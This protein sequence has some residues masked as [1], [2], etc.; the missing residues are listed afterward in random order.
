MTE[1]DKLR[2]ALDEALRRERIAV[3]ELQKMRQRAEIA[4]KTLELY[5]RATQDNHNYETVHNARTDRQAD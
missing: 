5:K 2:T 1:E 3:R 4:E